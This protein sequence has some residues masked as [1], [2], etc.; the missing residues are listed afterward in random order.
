MLPDGVSMVSCAWHYKCTGITIHLL[1]LTTSSNCFKWCYLTVMISCV[2]STRVLSVT[3]NSY[4]NKPWWKRLH[5]CDK[6]PELS[7][8]KSGCSDTGF[9]KSV[10]QPATASRW[11]TWYRVEQWSCWR[12]W[13]LRPWV[14][15]FTSPWSCPLKV[16]EMVHV[17]IE[18]W[19]VF[20]TM[21]LLSVIITEVSMSELRMLELKL[22]IHSQ[23]SRVFCTL[24][25]I[26]SLAIVQLN[27][28]FYWT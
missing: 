6:W 27:F 4:C 2:I 21:Y 5:T 22:I 9:Y 8:Y 18:C 15:L 12:W 25:Y 24:T 19:C 13:C 14:H 11:I 26:F 23:S 7:Y 16:S 1:N 20:T 10:K 3:R 28:V 17:L